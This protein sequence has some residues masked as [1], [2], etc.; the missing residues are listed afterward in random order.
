ML[1][2]HTHFRKCNEPIHNVNVSQFRMGIYI[3][4][5]I[6]IFI[7]YLNTKHIIIPSPSLSTL[8]IT[9]LI[10][11]RN[12]HTIRR[13]I[14]L[15]YVTQESLLSTHMLLLLKEGFRQRRQYPHH[16]HYHHYHHQYHHHRL[17]PVHGRLKFQS[18]L[19]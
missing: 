3:Y 6:F 8:D 10:I 19:V 9:W 13:E 5:Y 4:I 11:H 15:I 16:Y 12:R 2:L 18:R 17:V 7:F 14:C 1:A